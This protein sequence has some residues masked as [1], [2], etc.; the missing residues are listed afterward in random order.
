VVGGEKEVSLPEQY[1][2]VLEPVL[3]VA[4]ENLKRDGKLAMAAFVGNLSTGQTVPLVYTGDGSEESK[5]GFAH[6]ISMTAGAFAADFIVVLMES[7][8]LAP[9]YVHLHR[10]LMK[11]YGSLAACPAS[12]RA[13]VLSISVESPT[14]LWMS[15]RPIKSVP[16]SK[17]RK[18]FDLPGPDDFQ[19]FTEAAGRLTGLLPNSQL[20]DPTQE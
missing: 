5:D 11:K 15:Q 13:E 20:I 17:K 10:D 7:W 18:T 8:S 19:K 3:R 6:H 4:Q 14:A 9:R 2:R 1:F 16:P 12:Y